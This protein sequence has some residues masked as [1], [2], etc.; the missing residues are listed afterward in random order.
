MKMSKQIVDNR[1]KKI[2]EMIEKLG[3]VRVDDIAEFL[4]VSKMT[5]RRDLQILEDNGMLRRYYGGA[6]TIEE[7]EKVFLDEVEDARNRISKYAAE[8]VEDGDTIFINTSRTALSM[9]P[10]ITAKNVTV[11]TNNGNAI[12]IKH[13][14]EITIVLT[15]GEL[16]YI[17]GA[18]V[19]EMAVN[20]LM[21]ITAKK[22]FVGCSG[23]SMEYGMTTD[24]LNE[25]QINEIMLSR[26]DGK[27]YILA[28]S[29]KIGK[30]KAFVSCHI[31][32]V[33]NV[34]SDRNVSKE[35]LDLFKEK[36]IN[37]D[38]V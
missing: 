4:Q 34:I 27:A 10:Y 2:L 7:H 38:L 12:N 15:G 33:K 26:V 9:I 28:D 3:D 13:S 24:F 14:P 20:N 35:A 1:Q 30:I 21:K 23:L 8:L 16:R 18:M 22:S 36:N 31:D 25:V 5:I 11:V 6:R 17:K 29:T 32:E 19:G 37:V